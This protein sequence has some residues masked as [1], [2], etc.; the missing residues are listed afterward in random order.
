MDLDL[1][2]GIMG[3]VSMPFKRAG[4]LQPVILIAVLLDGRVSMPF[5]RAGW[6]QPPLWCW[7]SLGSGFNAL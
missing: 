3:R 2:R 4:W 7:Q 6:L 5:K 1:R